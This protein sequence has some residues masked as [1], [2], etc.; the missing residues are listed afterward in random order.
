MCICYAVIV[1]IWTLLYPL[2]LTKER[3][4]LQPPNIRRS[5]REL[6]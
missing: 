2:K 6:V 1:L 3:R 5:A 4:N